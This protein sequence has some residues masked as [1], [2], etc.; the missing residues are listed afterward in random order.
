MEDKSKKTGRQFP[1]PK[2]YQNARES[3][4]SIA[5]N[6]IRIVPRE[7]HIIAGKEL[8]FWLFKVINY[9]SCI[10]NS[11]LNSQITVGRLLNIVRP[12]PNVRNSMARK[13]MLQ[14]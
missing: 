4:S 2:T 5:K 1:N 3:H 10:Y 9:I 7:W 6:A 12:E 11:V 8:S 14:I 13:P